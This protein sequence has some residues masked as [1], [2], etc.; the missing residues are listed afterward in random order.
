MT[1]IEPHPMLS[2]IK[3]CSKCGISKPLD[4]FYSSKSGK[5]GKA[6]ECKKCSN[7]RSKKYN[8][9]H[10]EEI[11]KYLRRYRQNQK[12]QNDK[13]TMYENKSC[14]DYL[15]VV[16]GERLCRHLFKDVEV[17]PY[18]FPGYDIVCN[19]GKKINVKAACITPNNK[20]FHWKFNINYNKEPD[21]FILVAFD[22]RTDLNPLHMWMIPGKEI[23]HRSGKSIRP[24][25]IH[26]W[27]QWERSV[28]E[29]QSCC[30]ELKK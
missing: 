30:A 7:E 22:N 15:G 18:G 1:N 2:D 24:S 11:V 5:C 26:K 27:N 25:T 14:A 9:E 13:T 10:Q 3:T 17:M 20:Y 29:V 16:I 12:K 6:S 4:E 23:N 28:E 19:R 21:F 8:Q